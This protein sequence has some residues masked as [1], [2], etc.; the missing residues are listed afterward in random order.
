MAKDI[1]RIKDQA[2]LLNKLG[3]KEQFVLNYLD[4]IE[5]DYEFW[6]TEAKV[7]FKKYLNQLLSQR[8]LNKVKPHLHF[9]SEDINLLKKIHHSF[10]SKRDMPVI[11]NYDV[12]GES[13]ISRIKSKKDW[14]DFYPK[15]KS[16][17]NSLGLFHINEMNI[18]SDLKKIIK[19]RGY[20]PVTDCLLIHPEN[21]N[22]FDSNILTW[23]SKNRYIPTVN[24]DHLTYNF[25]SDICLS[26][27]ESQCSYYFLNFKEQKFVSAQNYIEDLSDQVETLMTLKNAA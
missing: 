14:Y 20:I 15:L 13:E 12:K 2:H 25:L 7:H 17:E 3:F 10:N 9:Y 27:N 23:V 8:S 19:P 26:N 5:K 1:Q 4:F 22:A 21:L 11:T 18:V 6:K 16:F 24:A